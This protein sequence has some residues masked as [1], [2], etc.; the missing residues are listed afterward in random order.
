MIN[1]QDMKTRKK[2]TVWEVKLLPQ[3]TENDLAQWIAHFQQFDL[4]M[5]TIHF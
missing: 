2:E 5:L 3:A 4:E 1:L